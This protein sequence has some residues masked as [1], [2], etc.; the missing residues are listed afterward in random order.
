MHPFRTVIFTTA[1]LLLRVYGCS[2]S[3]GGGPDRTSTDVRSSSGGAD[4]SSA[5][6]ESLYLEDVL[7][8]QGLTIVKTATCRDPMSGEEYTGYLARFG[9]QFTE[10][11]N[12]AGEHVGPFPRNAWC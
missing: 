9:Q 2:S 6:T 8:S 3:G 12:A 5:G 7:S 1:W 11:T 4:G 10:S